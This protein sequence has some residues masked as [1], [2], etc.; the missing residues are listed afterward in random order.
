LGTKVEKAGRGSGGRFVEG[1]CS[2]GRKGRGLAESKKDR[3][4]GEGKVVE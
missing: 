1:E 2:V 4:S 3:G